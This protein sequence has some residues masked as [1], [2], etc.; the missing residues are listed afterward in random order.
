MIAYWFQ[1]GPSKTLVLKQSKGQL[2]YNRENGV[3]NCSRP[4]LI[5]SSS[6]SQETRTGIKSRMCLIFSQIKLLTSELFALELKNNTSYGYTFKQ[7][8]L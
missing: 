5:R 4:F 6:N 2:T 8:Y 3:S 7:V 1:A